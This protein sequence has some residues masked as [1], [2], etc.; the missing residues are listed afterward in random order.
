MS[1]ANLARYAG[2]YQRRDGRVWRVIQEEG[3][4]FI[5]PNEN[6]RWEIRPESETSFF[7]VQRANQFNT[8]TVEVHEDG[9]V[10]GFVVSFDTG[11]E[12]SVQRE[13]TTKR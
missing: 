5:A 3:K 4:L 6:L 9:T 12:I 10:V 7:F 11:G 8:V 1:Q 2:D 13:G